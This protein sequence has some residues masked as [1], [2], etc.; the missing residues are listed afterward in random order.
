[1]EEGL[2]TFY[3][4]AAQLGEIPAAPALSWV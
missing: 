3:R 2:L 1:M 4:L